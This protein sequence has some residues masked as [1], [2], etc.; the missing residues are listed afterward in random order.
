MSTFQ[1]NLGMDLRSDS[2]AMMNMQ[3]QHQSHMP[4]HT[5]NLHPNNYMYDSYLTGPR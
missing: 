2:Q 3:Q 4:A 1:Q 5:S